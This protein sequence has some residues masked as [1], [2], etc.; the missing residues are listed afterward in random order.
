MRRIVFVALVVALLLLLVVPVGTAK[1]FQPP[2]VMRDNGVA[3]VGS[4]VL[5]APGTSAEQLGCICHQLR[6]ERQLLVRHMNLPE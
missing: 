2:V 5:A 1:T 4:D 6:H 3:V